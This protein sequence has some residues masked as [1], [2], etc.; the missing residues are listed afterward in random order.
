MRPSSSA[1]V[2]LVA[3]IVATCM[4]VAFSETSW[5]EDTSDEAPS[6]LSIVKNPDKTRYY[7]GETINL[8]GISIQYNGS[9]I[10]ISDCTY[11][12]GFITTAQSPGSFAVKITYLRDSQATCTLYITVLEPSI[13][14]TGVDKYYHVGDTVSR[15]DIRMKITDKDGERYVYGFTITPS[16]ITENTR[17]LTLRYGNYIETVP[18]QIA[19]D[20]QYIVTIQE[21]EYSNSTLV[22]G[23]YKLPQPKYPA[24][25]F[26]EGWV[27]ESGRYLGN[28]GDTIFVDRD[29]TCIP[30]WIPFMV[31]F[32]EH[33][34]MITDYISSDQTSIVEIP[35]TIAERPVYK[36]SES[37]F[38]NIQNITSISIPSSVTVIDPGAFRNLPALT[39]IMVSGSNSAFA[40]FD[41]V[42]YNKDGT[43]LVAVPESG[44]IKYTLNEQTERIKG[45]AIGAMTTT[46]VI[47]ATVDTLTLEDDSIQSSVSVE[48]IG[49]NA[50]NPL[51]L[52]DNS[53]FTGPT[54]TAFTPS[55][56]GKTFY[57]DTQP[58]MKYN[59]MM[60]IVIIVLIVLSF[61]GYYLISRS[62]STGRLLRPSSH[63]SLL[64]ALLIVT[65]I[66]LY[67][68][69]G[70]QLFSNDDLL[71]FRNIVL[72]CIALGLFSIILGVVRHL[73]MSKS[74]R[75]MVITMSAETIVLLFSIVTLITSIMILLDFD[76]YFD[77]EFGLTRYVLM[78]VLIV[79]ALASLLMIIATI[80][81][82]HYIAELNSFERKMRDVDQNLYETVKKICNMVRTV[83]GYLGSPEPD[84]RHVEAKLDGLNSFVYNQSE[85]FRKELNAHIRAMNLRYLVLG[86]NVFGH[87]QGL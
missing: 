74:E 39:S 80:I 53:A 52:Y 25:G 2:I 51:G 31:Q 27:D 33:G 63:M 50:L 66:A 40:S 29:L 58:L 19:A 47:P 76:A 78:I 14:I 11:T 23:N 79:D 43:T 36:L 65:A 64:G 16:V 85:E 28:S 62:I 46:I 84:L 59:G 42:L 18:I 7:P 69:Y 22:S 9:P 41:G 57:M 68:G 30:S 86:E 77:V 3:I 70:S 60:S 10:S 48:L 8:S 5:G 55:D 4:C 67:I 75:S 82:V 81:D 6:G 1:T 45:F 56:C 61:V 32:D 20:N 87:R 44:H 17:E 21:D 24:P 83:D 54:I 15:D 71:E 26:F 72:V 13:E 12:P 49:G 73:Q 38:N 35:A 34:A 37:A